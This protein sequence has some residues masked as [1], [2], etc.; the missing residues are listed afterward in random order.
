M[1]HYEAATA[2]VV[3]TVVVVPVA[4]SR[5]EDSPVLQ[6]PSISMCGRRLEVMG[7][8]MELVAG[9]PASTF[10]VAAFD[11]WV[12]IKKRQITDWF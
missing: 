8:K 1:E 10:G 9:D 12:H 4:R 3:F 7:A 11:K 2:S 6:H 5:S